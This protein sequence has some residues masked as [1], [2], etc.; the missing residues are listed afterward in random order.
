M[1]SEQLRIAVRIGPEEYPVN[2]EGLSERGRK[3]VR[4][5]PDFR[6][7]GRRNSRVEEWSDAG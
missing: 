7:A 3:G 6:P 5:D 1:V 4:V 2:F